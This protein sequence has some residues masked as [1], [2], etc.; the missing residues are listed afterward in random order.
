MLKTPEF[1][2]KKDALSR[3]I[4]SLLLPLSYIYFFGFLLK[5][6]L[7][8]TLLFFNFYKKKK[9][10]SCLVICIGNLTAGG[11][12]KTPT[13]IAIGKILQEM[14]IDFAFLSRGYGAKKSLKKNEMLRVENFSYANEVGDEPLLLEQFG[15]T[16][17]AK[18]RA[19]AVQKLSDKK[20]FDA[21][22]LD[23][24]M[25]N[26][27]LRKDFV[28]MVIDTQIGFGNGLMIPAGPMREPLCSGLK[29]S[30]LVVLIGQ[31]N[32]TLE[33]KL[34]T[35]KI[36]RA[37]LVAK[38][39]EQFCDKKLIAFCGLAYPQKFFSFL[40]NKNLKL[41]DEISFPD[42]HTYQNSELER[43]LNLAEQQNSKVITTK[44]D[45]VKFEKFFQKKISYLDVELE[46]ENKALI[47][48]QLKNLFKND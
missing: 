19:F 36:V 33:K 14:D 35:K 32:L 20:S 30:D 7:V 40:Q 46:F 24:G 34:K 18:N 44:K 39:L 8:R 42:H 11:S 43:I 1:W 21:I 29:K 38:N 41:V 9:Q 4:S 23:D 15:P 26:D 13:A 10:N 27:S 47:K 16:F 48:D 12:G 6:I 37:Q 28:I 22:V 45:W 5:K 2:T 3:L 17:I 31:K 25:Q